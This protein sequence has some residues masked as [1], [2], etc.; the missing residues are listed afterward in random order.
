MWAILAVVLLADALDMIDSTVTNIAAP[1]IAAHLHGGAGLIKWLGTSYMLAMGVLLVLGGRLGDRYGQRRLFLTGLTGFTLASAAAGLAPTPTVMILARVAQGAFGALLIPQG[2]AIMTRSFTRDMLGKAFGLFGPLLGVATVGGPVL[3]GVIIDADLF[4]LSWRPV[5]LV[6]LILG[7]VG[8]ALAVRLLPGDTGDRSITVDGWGAGLLA[9]AMFGMLYGLTEGS[10]EGWTTLPV[11]A[12]A[13]G[14]VAF[15]GFAY[16][17]GTA[18]D[19]LIK[20]SLLRNKGFTS[21]LTVG[22]V[23][24][25]ATTGLLYVL[26]LYLQQG[27]HTTP[28]GAALA[29]MPLTLGI[30]ASAFVAMSGLGAK[31]GRTLIFIGLST[32]LIG[33]GWTLLLVIG[34]GTGLSLWALAPALLVTGF[35]MG[36][37]YSTIFDVA[38]GDTDPEE[39]GSASG[40]LSSIQQLAAGIGSATV[41]SIF[42]QLSGTGID[43]A[44]RTCMI[45]VL[46]LVA[47]SL[48]IVGLMPRKAPAETGQH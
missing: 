2:M 28:R 44:M 39:A 1:T 48:P 40:S 36:C 14:L 45:V 38:L 33:G 43:H 18:R 27:V 37:C 16:R 26:S 47:V 25:A 6:N 35:G 41:V 12:V 15:G 30:I 19:P 10:T 7:G 23:V 17:Q 4:G 24:F 5:F 20:P 22:L 3:A 8:L 46:V 31:L 42:L 9:A 11:L 13:A 34:S 32:V 21:G 29:L